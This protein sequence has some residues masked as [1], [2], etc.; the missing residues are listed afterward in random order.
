MASS[1]LRGVNTINQFDQI[2]EQEN[3]GESE[4]SEPDNFEDG[5]ERNVFIFE[6][7]ARYQGQWKGNMRHGYG[8]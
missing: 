6:N 8:Q 5:E 2:N 7:G 3:W 4:E 1:Y